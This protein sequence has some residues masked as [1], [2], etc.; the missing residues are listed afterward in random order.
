ML[1]KIETGERQSVGAAVDSDDRLNEQLRVAFKDF[2]LP[3]P[4]RPGGDLHEVM[5][6]IGR[7]LHNESLAIKTINDRLL[8]IEQQTKKRG[9]RGFVR[10]LIA[11]CIGAAA[12]LVWLSYG[13]AAKRIIATRSPEL[14]WSPENKQ[15]IT[16]W[17]QQLGW[18]KPLVVES[19]A[20]PVTQTA[21]ETVAPN[22]PVQLEQMVQS[23]AT[24]RESV[25]QL[26]ARQ[27]SLVALGQIV[28][29]LT[30]SQD[31]IGRNIDRLQGAVAEILAK[32]PEPPPPPP[33]AA[34]PAGAGRPA[35]G[36]ALPSE[37]TQNTASRSTSL[38]VGQALT[39]GALR[40][41][42]GPDVQKL[43]GGISREKGG[44]IKCLSSHRIELSP[45]CDAYFSGMPVHGAAQKG[46]P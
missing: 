31:K 39:D 30:D 4:Q 45:T 3:S 11:I 13:E 38:P 32:M 9:S 40:A 6:G 14:G 35:P 24:L 43:C 16:N 17:V 28:D 44:V 42:Y 34:D 22:D 36:G 25:Q 29:Q 12:T 7:H 15:M 2:E 8:A 5:A 27:V 46:T 26:A 37:K 19:K 20:A 18:T 41:S 10:Y 1:G 23:L 33:I 21:P